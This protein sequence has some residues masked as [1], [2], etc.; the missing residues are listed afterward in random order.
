MRLWVSGGSPCD[1]E[2]A[3]YQCCCCRGYASLDAALYHRPD[4][5]SEFLL[6]LAYMAARK[7]GRG[8][9]K[10]DCASA[11][12]QDF[13]QRFGVADGVRQLWDA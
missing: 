2:M 6:V 11:S 9:L 1:L 10:V 4:Q 13:F 3:Y 7:L 12:Y 8:H 5:E